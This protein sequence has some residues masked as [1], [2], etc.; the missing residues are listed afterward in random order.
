M[1][2]GTTRVSLECPGYGKAVNRANWWEKCTNQ[3]TRSQITAHRKEETKAAFKATIDR[4]TCFLKCSTTVQLEE[5]TIPTNS[6]QHCTAL[7]CISFT[8][9]DNTSTNC[10]FILRLWTVILTQKWH[11]LYSWFYSWY[12]LDM[13]HARHGPHVCV[14]K[15]VG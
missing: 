1:I 6:W 2:L 5:K 7:Y 9:V 11:L 15:C 13:Q 8:L 4:N 10:I 3:P 14:W 12:Y